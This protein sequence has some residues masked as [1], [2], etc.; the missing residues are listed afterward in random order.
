MPTLNLG[1]VGFVNKGAY[2]G[3]TTPYKIN[4]IVV[5]GNTIYACILA[6]STSHLP[7]DPTYWQKWTGY[8][9]SGIVNTPAGYITSI[10]V[11]GAIDELQTI[12]PYYTGIKSADIVSAS[13]VNIGA[14]TGDY[15]HITGTNNITAFDIAP[16]G[17][18]RILVFD[19]ILTIT[20][21]A[22]S[23]ILPA[24]LDITTS[25]GD[26]SIF[27]SEGSGNWKCIAYQYSSGTYAIL[28]NSQ[29]F[30]GNNTF[31]GINNFTQ[32]PTLNGVGLN[33]GIRQTVRYAS[34]DGN[35]FP[36]YISIG[37]GLSVNIAATTTNILISASGGAQFNDRNGLVSSDTTISSLTGSATNY[38]YADI[39]IDGTVTLGSTL[40]AP[41]YEFGGT[42]SITSGQFTFNISDMVAYVGNGTTADQTWRVFIGEAIT[43]PT[44][45]TSVI[46][47]ALN[48]YYKSA[49]T[50]LPSANTIQNFNHNI[51]CDPEYLIWEYTGEITVAVGNL[52]I[53]D[54][55]KYIYSYDS[56]SRSIDIK[57]GMTKYGATIGAMANSGFRTIDPVT[58]SPVLALTTANCSTYQAIKRGW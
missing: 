43:D 22:T 25:N 36:N 37:T 28:G 53:G 46:N 41:V 2:V 23:M 45:V 40:L 31:T 44:S 38:L 27:V 29:T 42:P 49:L 50:A 34:T 58:F 11:Q 21:N 18:H 48:G 35:G 55:V 20:H 7:T 15:I 3:G 26:V 1:R 8:D 17:L 10:D 4:D 33:Y 51:G 16:A 14:A 24:G 56:S 9:A 32:T 54:N 6:H 57:I 39:A 52:A 47:Y 30:T 13:T 12:S 5:Y 19:D